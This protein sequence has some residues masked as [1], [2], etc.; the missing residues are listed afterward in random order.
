MKSNHVEIWIDTLIGCYRRLEAKYTPFRV[1]NEITGSSILPTPQLTSQY[2][3]WWTASR[4]SRRFGST[5]KVVAHGPDFSETPCPWIVAN[6]FFWFHLPPQKQSGTIQCQ[7]GWMID[8]IAGPV[9]WCTIWQIAHVI[10]EQ[11]PRQRWA[12]FFQR[13]LR[14]PTI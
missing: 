13:S 14:S 3:I 11:G 2:W 9:H 12:L 8:S 1:V 10:H 4:S 5:R 6:L 7:R